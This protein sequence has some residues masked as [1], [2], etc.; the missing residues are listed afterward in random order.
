M[1]I[2]GAEGPGKEGYNLLDF[3]EHNQVKL[4]W[5]P[6]LSLE[7]PKQLSVIIER[8]LAGEQELTLLCIEG[9]IINGPNGT[10]MFDTFEGKPKKEIIKT[11]SDRAEF[12]LAMGTC[13]SFGGIPAAPP[14]PTESTGLQFQCDNPGGL[15]DADWRS[16]AG[17]PVLNLGG[18]P[19]DAATMI[20]TMSWILKGMPLEL[21]VRNRPFTVNPCLSDALH[22]KCGTSEKVGYACYGCISAKFPIK[23]GMFR[24][25][26]HP[27]KEKPFDRTSEHTYMNY[28]RRAN[29]NGARSCG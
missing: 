12:V 1:A 20:K 4:L 25:V 14:N 17:L 22:Q 28:A 2:L 29:R 18:C 9:S 21:D 24:H 7:S 6:S 5:H 15:L 19:V 3:L 11:L 10:G 8:I 26:E 23:K 16:R 13:S 27:E